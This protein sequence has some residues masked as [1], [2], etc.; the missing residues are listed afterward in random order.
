MKFL[1]DEN[2]PRPAIQALRR[3]GWD[4]AS[5]AEDSAG[6]DDEIVASICA[7]QNRI[8][9]TFDKDFGELVFV[10]G[11]SAGSRIVLLRFM[12]DSPEDAANVAL[13]LLRSRQDFAGS[14]CVVTK[15]R[16]RIRPLRSAPGT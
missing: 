9:L 5:I 14:F 1:A 11:L 2:F 3:A 12:P 13:D 16:I 6:V 4:V 15:E 8:L 7:G 10:R